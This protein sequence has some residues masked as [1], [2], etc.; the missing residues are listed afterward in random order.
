MS[1][2][3]ASCVSLQQA[4]ISGGSRSAHHQ[5]VP[6]PA[7]CRSQLHG[8]SGR[9]YSPGHSRSLPVQWAVASVASSAA[10]ACDV[11]TSI[12][13]CTILTSPRQLSAL[14]AR[15]LCASNSC[16][17]CVIYI[18]SCQCCVSNFR[19]CAF[20]GCCVKHLH[21]FHEFFACH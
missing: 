5:H 2:P 11:R 4:L 14:P 18:A 13:G 15:V 21:E 10:N 12:A 1:P 17:K 16:C 3:R 9:L 7:M 6:W 19:S 8:S 20:N